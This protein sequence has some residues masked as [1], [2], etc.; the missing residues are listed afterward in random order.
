MKLFDMIAT[1]PV[2]Q[3]VGWVLLHSLWQGLIL[4]ILLKSALCLF[5]KTSTNAR[6]LISGVT[7]LLMMILPILTVL[8][9]SSKL[10]NF[11]FGKTGFHFT[12]SNEKTN[13]FPSTITKTDVAEEKSPYLV[14]MYKA[15]KQFLPWLV[16]LWQIGVFIS[17]L[18]LLRAWGYTQRLKRNK[19]HLVLEQ[20]K[21]TVQKLCKQLRISKPVILLESSLVEVPTVIGWIK[22]VILFPPCAITGLTIKQ[23]EL[24][25]IH[26]LAHIRRH[27]YL[28]N[29][30]QTIIEMFLFYHPAVWWVSKQIRNEREIACDDLAVNSCGHPLDYARALVVLEDIRKD[31][32]SLAMAASSGSLTKRIHRVVEA[33]ARHSRYSAGL[34]AVIFISVCMGT[35]GFIIHNSSETMEKAEKGMLL[36]LPP[37]TIAD[38]NEGKHAAENT[39]TGE[40]KAEFDSDDNGK[41][42]LHFQKRSKRGGFNESINILPLSEL[43]GLPTADAFSGRATV[44]FRIVREAGIFT[45]EGYFNEGKGTGF[46]TLT[47]SQNF[48]SE[49]RR[50]GYDNLPENYLF[51]AATEN[52]T[53]KLFE[54]LESAGYGLSFKE[55]IQA[56]SYKITPELIDAWRAAGFNNLSFKELTQLG[57]NGVKPEFINEIKAEGFPELSLQQAVRLKTH[58]VDRDFIKRVR[59][60]GFPEV[61][62]NE[63][64]DL[65][66]RDIIK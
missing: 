24:I 1:S 43:E 29:L 14:W 36:N 27:D 51:Y 64:I 32:S 26:E 16:L 6:Y 56:A 30:F 11:N 45:C 63:L 20:F 34:W 39:M 65:R 4:A 9:S 44:A 54:D 59:A 50:H 5:R 40:W 38:L 33:D 52:I 15:E 19:K 57:E 37:L 2:M 21:P 60:S 18:R 49:M 3:M 8:W 12:E 41:I 35:I 47:P 28:V 58:D 22:P 62:L 10:S 7:L 13:T 23:F 42:S 61:S 55:L 25:L 46:W 17:F 48:V 66:T 31:T 53:V